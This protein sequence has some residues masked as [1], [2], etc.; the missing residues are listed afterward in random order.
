MNFA[1]QIHVTQIIARS[2]FDNIAEY[3]T[4]GVRETHHDQP[5]NSRVRKVTKKRKKKSNVNP[6]ALKDMVSEV[7]T[8]DPSFECK[9]PESLDS[10]SSSLNFP[11]PIGHIMTASNGSPGDVSVPFL[12]FHFYV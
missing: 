1:I 6:N 11:F 9:Y 2:A 8:V 4:F 5:G 3:N 7:R 10:Q 12:R